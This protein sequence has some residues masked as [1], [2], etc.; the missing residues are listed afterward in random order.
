MDQTVLG[1]G[2]TCTFEIDQYV[3]WRLTEGL[4]DIDLTEQ[5]TADIESFEAQRPV[6]CPNLSGPRSAELLTPRADIKDSELHQESSH[7]TADRPATK[8]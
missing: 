2:S 8:N 4:D 1:A 3:K 7:G 6:F 5:A